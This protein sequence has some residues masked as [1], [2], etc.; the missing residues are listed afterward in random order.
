MGDNDE[1]DP[2]E[3]NLGARDTTGRDSLLNDPDVASPVSGLGGIAWGTAPAFTRES[4]LAGDV[5]PE[6]SDELDRI[7]DDQDASAGAAGAKTDS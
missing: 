6:M 2:G 1:R 4:D 7:G 5:P 3:G